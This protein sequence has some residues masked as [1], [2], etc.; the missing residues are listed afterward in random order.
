MREEITTLKS[1][2]P[3]I[4]KEVTKEV[5]REKPSNLPNDLVYALMGLK[6]KLSVMNDFY[7]KRAKDEEVDDYLVAQ[8]E[9]IR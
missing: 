8:V 4:I 7:D 6:A 5:D 9:E 1:R 3:T 2:E